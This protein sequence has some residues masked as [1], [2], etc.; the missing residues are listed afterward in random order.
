MSDPHQHYDIGTF[1]LDFPGSYSKL[2]ELDLSSCVFIRGRGIWSLEFVPSLQ[3]LNIS[4]CLGI[5]LDDLK[6]LL[7]KDR[8]L[9]LMAAFT[10]LGYAIVESVAEFHL[11]SLQYLDV[12]FPTNSQG[13]ALN[14]A[15]LH[16]NWHQMR[17][18]YRK[19]DQ[20]QKRLEEYLRLR[21][22]NWLFAEKN[23]P[24]SDRMAIFRFLPSI[25]HS[26]L[27]YQY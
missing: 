15:P 26:F 16:V 20:T 8:L 23:L 17:H 6:A 21:Y 18:S 12:S 25:I 3:Y 13:E 22:L 4:K 24:I 27:L 5:E 7:K 1:L 14:M 9:C 11:K 19:V 10:S 2:Q